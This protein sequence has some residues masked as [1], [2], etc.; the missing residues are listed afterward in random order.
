MTDKNRQLESQVDGDAGDSLGRLS[1]AGLRA[2]EGDE[3]G[4]GRRH[5]Q[6]GGRQPMWVV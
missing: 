2:M 6:Q 3:E 4:E 5:C 1:E